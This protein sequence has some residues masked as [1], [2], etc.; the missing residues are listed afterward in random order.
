MRVLAV[1]AHPV[2][3]STS[4]HLFYEAVKALQLHGAAVDVLDLYQHADRIPFLSF[5]E[6]G[7]PFES[8]FA[9]VPFYWENKER[10]MAADRLLI[11]YPVWWYAVPAI[12]KAWMDLIT[13]YAW[14]HTKGP[15]GNAK[16]HIK[17]ALIVNTADM[18]WWH[19]LFGSRNSATEM[20]T[21]SCK[22]L[23]IGSIKTYEVH[24][25]RKITAHDKERHTQKVLRL[26]SWLLQ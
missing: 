24:K 8:V 7:K 2:A 20:V 15:Y 9:N 14:A 12:M 5:P 11:V 10:F 22:Y 18:S 13:N 21:E 25:A 3:T 6:P 16:H 26:C 23:G 1:L 17:K 4:G 19:R